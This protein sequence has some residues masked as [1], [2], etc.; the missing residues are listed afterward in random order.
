MQKDLAQNLIDAL[1][2]EARRLYILN[3][4]DGQQELI[5]KIKNIRNQFGIEDEVLDKTCE[6]CQ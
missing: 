6:S 4:I 3:D 2:Q 5:R 1:Q